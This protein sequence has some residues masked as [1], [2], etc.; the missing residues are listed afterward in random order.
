M[1]SFPSKLK[2]KILALGASQ[3]ITAGIVT[4]KKSLYF[5]LRQHSLYKNFY[6]FITICKSSV[7][8]YQNEKKNINVLYMEG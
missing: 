3:L 1:P 7:A 4:N 5:Y 8:K 2:W 6:F